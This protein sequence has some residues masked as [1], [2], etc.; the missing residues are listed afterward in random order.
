VKGATLTIQSIKTD[1]RFGLAG[2]DIQAT[3]TKPDLGATVDVSLLARL[4]PVIDANDPGKLTLRVYVESL[5]PRASWGIFDFKVGGFVRDLLQVKLANELATMPAIVIPVMSKI[6]LT[7]PAKDTPVA[8]AGA[9]GT[10]HSPALSLDV[11]LGVSRM[12][13]LPDGLHIFGTVA[14]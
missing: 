9:K 2:L 7:L 6:P 13:F 4:D 12:L 3:A 1:L 8:F 5:V 10:V 14:I 11:T